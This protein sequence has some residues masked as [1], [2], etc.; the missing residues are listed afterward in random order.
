MAL[1]SAEADI[2]MPVI[3]AQCAR[4]SALQASSSIKQ[5]HGNDAKQVERQRREAE[6]QALH[7]QKKKVG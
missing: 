2:G 7:E 4:G 3:M 5:R 1:D 6:Q